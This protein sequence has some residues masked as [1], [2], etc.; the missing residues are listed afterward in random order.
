LEQYLWLKK[1]ARWAIWKKKKF[2]HG[3]ADC[4]IKPPAG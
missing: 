2:E 3:F 4:L 1:K